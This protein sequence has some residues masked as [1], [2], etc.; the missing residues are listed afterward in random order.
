MDIRKIGDL[1]PATLSSPGKTIEKDAF[2]QIYQEKISTVS[3]TA[4]P[5]L[6]DAKTDFIDQGDKVLDLLDAY[7]TELNNPD[8]NLKDIDPLVKAIENGMKLFEAKRADHS[9]MDEE[10]QGIAEDL[11]I[12]ANVALLKFQRGDYI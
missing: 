6:F 8:K 11:S 10:M 5:F 3:E 2:R 4:A 7:A 9:G 12:T 1:S